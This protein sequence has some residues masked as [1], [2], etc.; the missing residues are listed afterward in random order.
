MILDPI[1]EIL[2]WYYQTIIITLIFGPYNLFETACWVRILLAVCQAV[3]PYREVH[4]WLVVFV[5]Q[6]SSGSERSV[7]WTL[8]S[9]WCEE[10]RGRFELGFDFRSKFSLE[11]KSLDSITIAKAYSFLVGDLRMEE[12]IRIYENKVYTKYILLYIYKLLEIIVK[13]KGINWKENI[14][15]IQRNK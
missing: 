15:D 5:I 4:R 14:I 12:F 7:D 11:R 8:Q 1:G 3:R 6:R 9:E 2:I 10:N 13:V